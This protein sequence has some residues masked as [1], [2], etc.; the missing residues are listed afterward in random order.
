MCIDISRRRIRRTCRRRRRSSGG[1]SWRRRASGS[2]RPPWLPPL[3][4]PTPPPPPPHPPPPL[5]PNP[6][7]CTPGPPIRRWLRSGAGLGN[8]AKPLELPAGV[9]CRQTRVSFPEIA[10]W[11]AV[12]ELIQLKEPPRLLARSASG[13][14]WPSL[15]AYRPCR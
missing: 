3:P 6:R 5:P 11:A 8:S 4:S 15:C 2:W 14:A 10:A 1:W 12:H 9:S 7:P 13:R